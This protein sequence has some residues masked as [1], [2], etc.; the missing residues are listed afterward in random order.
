M[1][2]DL[3]RGVSALLAMTGA[4][5]RA[6]L[7]FHSRGPAAGRYQPATTR[8][9]DASGRRRFGLYPWGAAVGGG[10]QAASGCPSQRDHA[11]VCQC[12]TWPE[13]QPLLCQHTIAMNIALCSGEAGRRPDDQIEQIIEAKRRGYLNAAVPDLS[14]GHGRR[15]F[16]PE[17]Q[18]IN[19][20]RIRL[21]VIPN[22]HAGLVL[23]RPFDRRVQFCQPPL[24]LVVFGRLN[25]PRIE[26][27]NIHV[28]VRLRCRQTVQMIP[29]GVSDE[30]SPH[31]AVGQLKGSNEIE[32]A[33]TQQVPRKQRPQVGCVVQ[34]FGPASVDPATGARR[35]R[36][37]KR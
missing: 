8:G 11:L 4:Q 37:Q 7:R 25:A 29:H 30:P 32:N 28:P 5:G 3:A 9:D 35:H 19:R 15:R 14:Y 36:W 17:S 22:M 18:R 2:S 6:T 34:N 31:P 12:Q 26:P 10:Y 1:P 13:Q 33:C 16:R 24:N 23:H 20:R 27:D 21:V